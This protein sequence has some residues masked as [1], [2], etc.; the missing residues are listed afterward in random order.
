MGRPGQCTVTSSTTLLQTARNLMNIF[1]QNNY[2]FDLP[3][4]P[5]LER[6]ELRGYDRKFNDVTKSY[7]SYVVDLAAAQR[8]QY[9]FYCPIAKAPVG[10]F[11]NFAHTKVSSE[12]V[13]A[14]ETK[15]PILCRFPPTYLWGG[16]G[17]YF[18]A[19]DKTVKTEFDPHSNFEHTKILSKHPGL[20]CSGLLYAVFSLAGLKVNKEH[21]QTP[22]A[23]LADKSVARSYLNTTSPTSCFE[24][25]LLSSQT[26]AGDV[27]PWKSH[28]VM[29]VESGKDPFG[30]AFTKTIEDCRIRN[31]D[32]EKAT[33]IVFNSKGAFEM[34]DPGAEDLFL[35]NHFYAKGIY[36]LFL[37][38]DRNNFERLRSHPRG[39]ARAIDPGRIEKIKTS[40][41][42]AETGKIERLVI[43]SDLQATG[44]GIGVSKMFWR[45]FAFFNPNAYFELAQRLCAA[46]FDYNYLGHDKWSPKLDSAAPTNSKSNSRP[47]PG[48]KILRHIA[49]SKNSEDACRCVLPSNEKIVM[50]ENINDSTVREYLSK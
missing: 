21:P 14:A 29:I 26:Q 41:D 2:A 19:G 47:S 32:P 37:M 24:E 15:I 5:T 23:S 17:W 36:Q 48:I 34:P 12:K 28:I 49:V 16:T 18:T 6:G 39:E 11:T 22:S 8:S 35:Q 9:Y 10:T 3:P 25:V 40:L 50:K 46:K 33:A 30:I 20:D 13:D 43:K 31:L 42:P 1:Y 44:V 7:N 45:D 4:Y 27:I 38:K